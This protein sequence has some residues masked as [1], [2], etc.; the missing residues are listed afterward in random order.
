M[1]RRGVIDTYADILRA[2]H[3]GASKT[4]IVYRANLNYSRCRR[5]IGNLAKGGL[6]KVQNGSPSSWAATDRGREFLQRHRELL[7]GIK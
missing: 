1:S 3:D 7:G 2:V 5:H 6:V 4:R